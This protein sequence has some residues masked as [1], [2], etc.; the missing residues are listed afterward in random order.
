M[1]HLPYLLEVLH[2]QQTVPLLVSLPSSVLIF[3]VLHVS[4][5]LSIKKYC[6]YVFEELPQN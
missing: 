5:Q 3:G 1:H 2:H 4:V 6:I